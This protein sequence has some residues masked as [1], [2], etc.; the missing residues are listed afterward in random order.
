[1]IDMI[2]ITP[3]LGLIL[4]PLVYAIARMLHKKTGWMLAHPLLVSSAIIIGLLQTSGISYEQ[5]YSG[6]WVWNWLVGPATVALA[7]PLYRQRQSLF[8]NWKAVSCGVFSGA[9]S[10][11]LSVWIVSKLIGLPD[12][13]TLS[14]LPK[15]VTVPIAIGIS[16][17]IDGIPSLTICATIITGIFGAVI[18]PSVLNLV[19]VRHDVSRGLALGAAAHGAGVQQALLTNQRQ[20]AIAG[21]SVGLVGAIAA[22]IIPILVKILF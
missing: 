3:L 21:L 13:V 15:S 4:T 19:R 7:V 17:V 18:G 22:I 9:V 2:Y 1:M 6:A 5:Y 16:S 10:G 11:V 14:L 12:Q 8:A 20:G